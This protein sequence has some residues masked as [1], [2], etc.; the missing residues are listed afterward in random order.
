MQS[1]GKIDCNLVN[2]LLKS[3]MVGVLGVGMEE[4]IEV[5]ELGE[6]CIP[7]TYV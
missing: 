2:A 7:N 1:L 3:S 5:G 4:E 6:D